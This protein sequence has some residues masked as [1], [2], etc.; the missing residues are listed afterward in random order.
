MVLRPTASSQHWDAVRTATYG[1]LRGTDGT[2]PVDQPDSI[3]GHGGEL[4]ITTLKV[5]IADL[6][7]G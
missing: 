2:S 4:P 5:S 6:S 1:R 3:E 7:G